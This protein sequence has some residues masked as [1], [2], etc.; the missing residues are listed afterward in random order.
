ME[1]GDFQASCMSAQRQLP[2]NQHNLQENGTSE[3]MNSTQWM[4]WFVFLQRTK[5]PRNHRNKEPRSQGKQEPNNHGTR[6]PRQQGTREPMNQRNRE[7]RNRGTK[8]QG[9]QGTEGG[10]SYTDFE[11]FCL[12][13]RFL[14]SKK[15]S[16]I[17]LRGGWK[18]KTY[19]DV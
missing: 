8:K 6:E 19:A 18:G 5:E 11:P 1:P 4:Y 17:P 12:K 2:Q 7:P 10:T 9:N 15:R 3:T 13:I 16:R 14:C